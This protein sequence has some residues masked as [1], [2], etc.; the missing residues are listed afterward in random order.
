MQELSLTKSTLYYFY[1]YIY[2]YARIVGI[3][4][5]KKKAVFLSVDLDI[6]LH[7]GDQL[8]KHAVNHLTHPGSKLDLLIPLTTKL[9]ARIPGQRSV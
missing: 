4:L 6:I 7:D 9:I 5:S 8:V 2:I 3:L 1:Y